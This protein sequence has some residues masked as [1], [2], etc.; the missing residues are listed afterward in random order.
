MGKKICFVSGSSPKFLGGVSLYQ[1]NLIDYSKKKNFNLKFYWIYPGRENKVFNSE[2]IECIEVRCPSLFFIGGLVFGSK[3]KNIL[4]KGR[5][6]IIN[7]HANWGY[8]LKNYKKSNAELV[9]HTFHGEDHYYWRAKFEKFGFLKYLFYPLLS[10][11]SFIER[12]PFKNA[13]KIICVSEK[14]RKQIEK[15]HGNRKNIEV[16]RTGVDVNNFKI[17]N[18]NKLRVELGL[19]KEKTFGLY[20][21]RGGY[22]IKGLDRAVSLGKEIYNL[23]KNFRLIVI[24]PDSKKVNSILN[25]HFIISLKDVPRDKMPLYYSASDIFFC[26]SRYEGGAPTLSVSEAVASGC[27]IVCSKDSDQEI[28]L[29]GKDGL[30]IENFDKSA[31]KKIYL[32]LSN[33]KKL[34]GVI[35]NAKN[36]IK[37]LSLEKWGER[38]FK[39]LLR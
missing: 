7:T 9:V 25:Q 14:V 17:R 39:I 3:V 36:K 15:I 8:C 20:V 13:D 11:V 18:K 6:D 4:N 22:W 16:I 37:N 31:A 27:L 24:G 29:D 5:Y 12:T 38:Y 34:N 35:R 23:N 28:I 19:D 2:G 1:R 26:M 33:K 30:I 32:L 21:G 10:L